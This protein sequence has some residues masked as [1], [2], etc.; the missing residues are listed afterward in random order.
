MGKS[1]IEWTN[2]TI[3]VVTGCTKISDG[4]VN[5]Y[6]EKMHNRLRLMYSKKYQHDFNTVV[7][8]PE[9]LKAYKFPKKPT[10]F[11]LNSMSDTFHEKLED[12]QIRDI[13]D[14]LRFFSNNSK[15]YQH[16]FQI[17]TKRAERLY[18][19][20]YPE[21]VWLGVTVEHEKYKHRI[22]KLRDIDASVKFLSCEPLL[23]DLGELVLKGIDWVIVGGE[24]S[25][26]ARPMHPS[27]V[28][29]IQRQCKGQG[30]AFYFKQWGEFQDGS[31]GGYYPKKEYTVLN[32]GDYFNNTKKTPE[33]YLREKGKN[34]DSKYWN[35]LK[36]CIMSKVGKKKAGC[37]LDEVE[38]KEYPTIGG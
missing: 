28:K 34:H 23:S 9:V 26:D 5:C 35:S 38:Y 24:S 16:I 11:F 27:W 21:N 13:L 20:D 8:H 18:N 12:W 25:S 31:T 15:T 33:D 22:D 10:M 37:L 32:N 17:L 6:A 29:N 4:C 14:D 1:K 7:Y 30:V 36:P 19:F 3:N 2:A